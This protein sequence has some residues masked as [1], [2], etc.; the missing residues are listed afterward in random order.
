MVFVVHND[1]DVSMEN[2][3]GKE[4]EESLKNEISHQEREE[5]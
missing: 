4:E 5:A 3:E 1:D 2:S